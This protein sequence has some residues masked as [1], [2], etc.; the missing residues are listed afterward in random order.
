[1]VAYDQHNMQVTADGHRILGPVIFTNRGS[2][3]LLV[4]YCIVILLPSPRNGLVNSFFQVSDKFLTYQKM[5]L[6]KKSDSRS[7]WKDIH[8]LMVWFTM[9]FLEWLLRIS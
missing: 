7:L 3:A 6:G 9:R 1:M 2:L 4:D 5:A 8:P